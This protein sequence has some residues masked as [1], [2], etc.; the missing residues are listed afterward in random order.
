D[1][2]GRESILAVH[3][4]GKP[5]AADVDMNALAKRTIGMSGADLANVLNEG[6][7]LAARRGRGE[8]SIDVLEEATDSVV[9]GPRRMRRGVSEH[10]KKFTAY[11]ES[12]HALAAWAME[13][14]EPVHKVTILARGRTGGHA[15]VVPEDDKS[16][17]T[18]ADM[19]AR[20]VM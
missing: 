20:I 15:L 6:A 18:R 11:H 17:M 14:L 1:L 16:L 12:G 9:G 4:Q 2:R 19:L 8:S 7:L 10:E 3:S 5:L 13:D